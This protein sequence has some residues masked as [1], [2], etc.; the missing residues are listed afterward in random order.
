GVGSAA[1]DIAVRMTVYDAQNRPVFSIRCV[2]NAASGAGDVLLALGKYHIRI[3]AGTRTGSPLPTISYALRG[4]L[5]SD[6]IDP[7]PSDPTLAPAGPNQSAPPADP[8]GTTEDPMDAYL[9]LVALGDPYSNPW[10]Y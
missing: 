2:A 9:G 5:R 1:G 4:M 3:V 6:P 8:Y 10:P 7:N